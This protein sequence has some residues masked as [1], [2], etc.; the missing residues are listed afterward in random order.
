MYRHFLSKE[1]KKE[2]NGSII[3]KVNAFIDTKRIKKGF[4]PNM[5]QFTT[6]LCLADLMNIVNIMMNH[7]LI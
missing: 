5:S 7:L 4:I 1:S 2:L 3:A 6:T